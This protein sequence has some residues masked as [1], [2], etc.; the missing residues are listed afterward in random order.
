M[1]LY[2][3][4][5]IILFLI[6]LIIAFL[7]WQAKDIIT[8][9]YIFENDAADKNLNGFKI[10]HISDLHNNNCGKKIAAI[11]KAQSPDIIVITGDLIDSGNTNIDI[12]MEFISKIINI[13]PI[14]YVQGNHEARLENY[15]QFVSSLTEMGVTVLDNTSA[16]FHYNNTAVN[17]IGIKSP[18]YESSFTAK[19]EKSTTESVKKIIQSNIKENMLNVLL[20]HN[21]ELFEQYS[22]CD[23]DLVF[24][25]HAHGGVVRLPFIGGIIA[26]NQGLFP[27]LTG[28]VHTKNNTSIVISRGVGNHF[29]TIRVF[30]RPEV[31]AIILKAISM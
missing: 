11:T 14:Y 19:I 22:Q 28:G 2:I 7:I 31:V 9:K 8:T 24:S 29:P 16:V 10:V 21:P 30:N 15:N 25:G 23:V 27:K 13:A 1:N 26:P 12:A 20:A 18:K 17:L 6:L 5:P 3:I 4:I